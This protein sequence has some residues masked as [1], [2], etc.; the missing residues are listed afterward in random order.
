M[1]PTVDWRVRAE[2]EG[3]GIAN[4]MRRGWVGEER[5]E[6]FRVVVDGERRKGRDRP[7]SERGSEPQMK[8]AGR[9]KTWQNREL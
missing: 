6:R 7:S 4:V 9:N 2:T 1:Q 8:K 5:G 3:T